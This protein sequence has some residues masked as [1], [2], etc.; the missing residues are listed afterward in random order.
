MLWAHKKGIPVYLHLFSETSKHGSW[1]Q[2]PS[3]ISESFV[4]VAET[5]ARAYSTT[6]TCDFLG[7]LKSKRTTTNPLKRSPHIHISEG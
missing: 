2:T 7:G 3:S 4:Y 5:P 1:M 6:D